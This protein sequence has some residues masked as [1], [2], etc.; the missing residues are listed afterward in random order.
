MVLLRIASYGRSSALKKRFHFPFDW[1]KLHPVGF[2]LQ[3]M[4]MTTLAAAQTSIKA[5]YTLAKGATSAAVDHE[6]K[7]RMIQIQS[8][9]LDAQDKLGDAQA[10][11]I[12]L[13]HQVAELREK[14]RQL[15]GDQAKLAAYSL[16]AVEPGKYLYKF[17]EEQP[18]AVPHYACPTCFGSGKVTV[19]QSK[20]T[21]THQIYYYCG[22]CQFGLHVG[23]S[24]PPLSIRQLRTASPR[25]W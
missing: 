11:R 21:G 12:D 3:H 19:L 5:L 9:I 23:P 25:N 15:E 22:T 16:Y 13:L 2:R 18:D 1:C 10:E 6:L 7:A 14:V 4:D 24:D 8:G 17:N 20:K